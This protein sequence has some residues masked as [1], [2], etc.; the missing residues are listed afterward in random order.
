MDAILTG[1]SHL[2]QWHV[3]GYLESGM[4]VDPLV[5]G[6]RCFTLGTVNITS[7]YSYSA[8]L[9]DFPATM[10][11][12]QETRL[13]QGDTAIL[14]ALRANWQLFHPELPEGT[15]DRRTRSGG[16]LVLADRS[17]Q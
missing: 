13:C 7:I 16:V 17:W 4:D 14:G 1:H 9:L 8:E 3:H 15:G 6:S 12:V 2:G 5:G 11:A 10:V